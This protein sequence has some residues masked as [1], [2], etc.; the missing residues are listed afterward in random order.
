ML[1]RGNVEEWP[2]RSFR[3]GDEFPFEGAL[4][5]LE[6]QG[7]QWDRFQALFPFGYLGIREGQYVRLVE[8]ALRSI[9]DV[10]E[11]SLFMDLLDLQWCAYLEQL[12]V[13][14]S[15]SKD[16]DAYLGEIHLADA[17]LQIGSNIRNQFELPEKNLRRLMMSVGADDTLADLLTLGISIAPN[18]RTKFR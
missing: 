17:R 16:E 11:Q 13:M 5:Q 4:K 9:N 10:S 6:H 3:G 8:A 18:R 1:D 12:R 14:A 2:V 15:F 7:F